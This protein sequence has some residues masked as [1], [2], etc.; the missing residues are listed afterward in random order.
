MCVWTSSSAIGFSPQF[1][2]DER[3]RDALLWGIQHPDHR[4]ADLALQSLQV[5]V[6]WRQCQQQR[7]RM[8]A[9]SVMT[10]HFHASAARKLIN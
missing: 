8:A 9:Q 4:P 2:N 1:L 6:G 10:V 5:V 7:T 3:L